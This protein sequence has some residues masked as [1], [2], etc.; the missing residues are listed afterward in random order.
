MSEGGFLEQKPRSPTGLAI[1]IVGHIAVLSA[2]ALSKMDMPPIID[3][4]PLT[5]KNIPLPKDP[6]PIPPEIK[7]KPTDLPQH[8]SVITRPEPIIKAP[9]TPTFSPPKEEPVDLSYNVTPPGKIDVPVYT[10][11]PPPKPLPDP[12]RMEARLDP[13]SELLPDYPPEEQRA[14]KEGNVTIRVVIGP[15][16]RVTRA[17]KV[18]AASEAFW[19]ATERHAIRNWRFK[20]A[21]VDGKPV[22]S[23]KVMTVRFVLDS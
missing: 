9:T 12:V 8:K 15:D 5:V 18:A 21:T 10:Q 13:R 22:E 11:P 2:L 1:V 16:G 17:E 6:P 20:P 23:T 3:L 14:E 4:G 7:Q 19:R